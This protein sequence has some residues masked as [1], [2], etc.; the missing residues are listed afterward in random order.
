MK[1]KGFT[2][3]EVIVAMLILSI[4]SAITVS[5][6]NIGTSSY[7]AYNTRLEINREVQDAFRRINLKIPM[8]DPAQIVFA[9]WRRFR[10]NTTENELIQIR[11]VNA[12]N[13]FQYR[14][15]TVTNIVLVNNVTNFQIDYFKQDGSSWSTS[16]PYDEIKSLEI[17]ITVTRNNETVSETIK[18]FIRN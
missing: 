3:V 14:D 17:N 12:D 10:F 5:I 7:L 11:Y 9:N 15:D 16:D 13:E 4:I 6:L 18:Y 8:A 1:E 2:L